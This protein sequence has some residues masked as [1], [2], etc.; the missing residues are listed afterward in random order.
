MPTPC[1]ELRPENENTG[2]VNTEP[3]KG[4]WRSG[5]WNFVIQNSPSWNMLGSQMP[6]VKHIKTM[7]RNFLPKRSPIS[8]LKDVLQQTGS[9]QPLSN[10]GAMLS[11]QIIG[12][13]VEKGE[14]ED[15]GT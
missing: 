14:A 1:G 5:Q 11:G 4:T 12:L 3:V 10:V 7:E 2:W 8:S 13:E 15:W 6:K 9:S